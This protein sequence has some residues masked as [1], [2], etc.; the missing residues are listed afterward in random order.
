MLEQSS[1]GSPEGVV[2]VTEERLEVGRRTVESG[3]VRVRKRVHQDIEQ[4]NEPLVAEFVEAKRVPVG[5]VLQEP[6]GIRQEGDVTIVPVIQERLVMHKELVLVEEIHLTRRR[7][8]QDANER[9][10]LRRESVVVERFDP[11][12]QQWLSQDEG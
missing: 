6:V 9:V 12:T 7:E 11:E 8:V 4:L 5:R 10:T 2:P 1:A 3:A